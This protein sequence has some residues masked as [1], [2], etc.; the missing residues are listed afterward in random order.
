M[1]QKRLSEKVSAYFFGNINFHLLII[2][3][4]YTS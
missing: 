3:N 1:K 2:L 4:P